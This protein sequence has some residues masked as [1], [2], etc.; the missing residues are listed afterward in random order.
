V[1]VVE[2]QA[3][4]GGYA[5]FGKQAGAVG[6]AAIGAV[7][8][9]GEQ[10]ERAFRR[11]QAGEAGRGQRAEQMRPATAILRHVFQQFRVAIE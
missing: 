1:G 5:G 6:H 3:G 9:V 11:G 7:R 4:A 2:I 8:Y 10:I